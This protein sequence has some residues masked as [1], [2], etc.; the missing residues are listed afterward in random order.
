M[1]AWD[2]YDNKK[3]KKS[4]WA[5]Y[6]K[7]SPETLKAVVDE[8]AQLRSQ[9][10]PVSTKK[11]RAT[12][13]WGGNIL[14]DILK[15]PATLLARPGQA[16]AAAKGFTP[17]EQKLKSSYLGDIE[18]VRNKKDVVKD[19]GRGIELISYGVGVGAAKNAL[20]ATAKTSA[21]QIAKRLAVEGAASGFVGSTGRVITEDK[22]GWEA[23]KDI[24][25]GTAGGAVLGGALGY[26]GGRI[27]GKT[28][29]AEERA[30]ERAFGKGGKA[31]IPDAGTPPSTY[32]DPKTKLLPAPKIE[33]PS[34]EVAASQRK[35]NEISL[36]K[37][38]ERVLSPLE[39][40]AKQFNSR[41]DFIDFEINKANEY[42]RL[43]ESG[44]ISKGKNP[45]DIL[46]LKPEPFPV[47]SP[48]VNRARNFSDKAKFI[49]NEISFLKRTKQKVTSSLL[50]KAEKSW[51]IAH[52]PLKAVSN[53]T[54]TAK[55][56]KVR[57]PS[58]KELSKVWD[59]IHTY[60]D[61]K[62]NPVN[63]GAITKTPE[64]Q[65]DATT[66]EP[67]KTQPS[68]TIETPTPNQSST[69]NTETPEFKAIVEEGASV[70][71]KTDPERFTKGNRELYSE[72]VYSDIAKDPE[73]VKRIA[74]GSKEATT[75]GV[76]AD[77]YYAIAKNE[78][79]KSGDFKLMEELA[80][81]DVGSI[82]GQKLEAN[83][84]T[85]EGDI[86]DTLRE[87][88]RAR[89]DKIKLSKKEL[90]K[91][92]NELFTKIKTAVKNSSDEAIKDLICK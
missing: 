68:S 32:R 64:I 40:T 5:K 55:L 82:S 57:V 25:I 4:A 90:S 74:M 30:L 46:K 77:A 18:T 28:L 6:D 88:K 16:L 13:T 3:S 66:G 80:N 10:L 92:E 11:T 8:K 43:V 2:N 85:Q 52:T 29:S 41:K 54:S 63:K 44:N 59:N 26:A 20:G 14:R 89:A 35:I 24:G 27:A 1:G 81:S 53:K 86:I 12:P 72:T 79:V 47:K 21:K 45:I 70:L 42:N 31:L 17:E 62:T 58:E 83:K 15:V 75:N 56:N 87:I 60:E 38:E 49:Q 34:P 23:I 61:V 71:D 51:D 91:Q 9:G 39:K 50:K 78:A 36:P 48:Q 84:L 76:P 73:K 33:L 37:A 7:N 19:L 67:I 65:Y 22:K 69:V